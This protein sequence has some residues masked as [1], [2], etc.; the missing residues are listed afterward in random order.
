MQNNTVIL[1]T[2]GTPAAAL[3]TLPRCCPVNR[4]LNRLLYFTGQLFKNRG[5]AVNFAF[6][7]NY[8]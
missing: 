6:G 2:P 3:H 1:K 4:R 7:F 8:L 5:F